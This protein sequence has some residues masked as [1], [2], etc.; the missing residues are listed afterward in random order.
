M[1]A[2][3]EEWVKAVFDH[4][5]GEPEWYWNDAFDPHWESLGM[6]DALT[7]SYLMR[8]F[9]EPALL[10]RYSLEQVAQAI[11]F[12]IG[13]SSPAQVSHALVRSD[14]PLETR[15]ACV[16]AMTEF[17]A[18]FVAPAAPGPADAEANPFH[19][20]CYMWWDIFPACPAYADG[21]A[22]AGEP[23]LHKV[24]LK[25][26]AEVLELPCELCRLSA[27]HGLNHWRLHYATEVELI[28]DAFLRNDREVTPRIREY[29][30][31]A[32]QGLCQ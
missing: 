28:V 24:C 6:S 15:A 11:W 16:Q 4:P 5:V 21:G 31:D 18:D 14:V 1:S 3:F 8:L 10:K 2:T 30:M 13:E 19:G 12:L 29:A 17:F 32:R 7:V 26:M 20:A 22:E 9:Q 27:L 23:E 25:V